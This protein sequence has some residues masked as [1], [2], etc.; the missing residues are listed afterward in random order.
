MH[1]RRGPE[2]SRIGRNLSGYVVG[3]PRVDVVLRRCDLEIEF[4][5]RDRRFQPGET[6]T[7]TVHVDVSTDCRCRGLTIARLW[8]THGMGTPTNGSEERRTLFEGEWEEGHYSYPFSI[9]LPNGPVS[10][11]G[12]LLN[13]D[14]YLV[15]EA[16][17]PWSFDPDDERDF[18]V[19]PAYHHIDEPYRTGDPECR[20]HEAAEERTV[21]MQG[22]G[23]WLVGG[24]LL[25]FSGMSCTFS[26]PLF[27]MM[28]DSLVNGLWGMGMVGL[29]GGIFYAFYALVLRNW[30]SERKIGSV[31]IDVDD[32]T[33]PAGES[34][35]VEVSIPPESDAHINEITVLLEGKEKVRYRQGTDTKTATR[36]F[37]EIE[38]TLCDSIDV[39]LP[40]GESAQFDH[41]IAIPDD[42]PPSFFAYRN[43]VLWTIRVAIDI[44][45]W[46]DWSDGIALDVVPPQQS[47]SVE[48]ELFPEPDP[49][50]EQG[51]EVW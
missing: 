17:I 23:K 45:G 16:D 13:V 38:E 3:K 9:E 39:H 2:P 15:A 25:M 40:D 47:R 12:D 46:P 4:D 7:G 42:A 6:V 18:V 27:L 30:L 33:V 28:G 36:E 43:K 37:C 51:Q 8:A 22:C 10:Y 32:Q 5:R 1:R 20:H 26:I 41:E 24:T 34:V 44:E 48:G 49:K 31:D 11:R 50:S 19:E 35:T 14:W 21:G 29:G